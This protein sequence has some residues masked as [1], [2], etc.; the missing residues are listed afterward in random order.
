MKKKVVQIVR[1]PAGGIRK[2]I[3]AIVEGLGEQFDFYFIL[4]SK[5]GDLLY[6]EF[7]ENYPEYKERVFNLSIKDQ[8]GLSDVKNLVKIIKYL[9]KIKADVVHG[10]GA[11]GGL[12]ARLCGAFCGL[13]T[14]YTA[15]GGSLHNMHGRI[16]GFIYTLVEK[17]LYFI[18]DVLIFESLYT[19][20]QFQKKIYSES[21]KFHLISNAIS[22]PDN[23]DTIGL[24]SWSS[25]ERI[26]IAAFGLLRKIKGHDLA[27]EAISKLVKKG[28][29]VTFTIYGSGEEQQ[30]LEALSRKLGVQERF[31]IV[32]NCNDVNEAMRDCELV[33]H[34]S[35]FES[36][37]Y[38][39][40][41]A[42]VNGVS[43]ISS[44]NG[45]LSQVMD[46]GA[47]G[48]C[49]KGDTIEEIVSAIEAAFMEKNREVRFN[50]FKSHI[51]N[52]FL[53]KDF[54]SRMGEVYRY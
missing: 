48:F 2:H 23:F 19:M 17:L 51:M 8:P 34:S 3:L 4:D 13:R 22:V 52:N 24:T 43:V 32:T 5:G 50:H 41:E 29:D 38:V 35:L 6:H 28:Y 44:L 25:K 7:L 36:F 9:K 10:H 33:I 40:L 15:H 20:E 31:S 45:G 47:C 37:G 54:L 1:V 12:Y 27:L 53:E 42:T 49:Y 21:P 14:C 16:K 18:S 30:S 11:K 26:R 46:G 39:P